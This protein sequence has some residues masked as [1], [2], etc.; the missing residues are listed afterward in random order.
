MF[1]EMELFS[2]RIFSEKGFFHILGNGTF[3][4]QDKNNSVVNFPSSKS[5]KSHSEKIS[6]ISGNGT[7]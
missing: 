3:W 2:P 5:K 1:L 4:P 7:F 6:N